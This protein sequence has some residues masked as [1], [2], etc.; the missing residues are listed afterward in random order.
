MLTE[1]NGWKHCLQ[2]LSYHQVFITLLFDLCTV[3]VVCL[4][5]LDNNDLALDH[6]LAVSLCLSLCGNAADTCSIVNRLEADE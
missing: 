5:S 6:V 4:S 3:H 2:P 1:N